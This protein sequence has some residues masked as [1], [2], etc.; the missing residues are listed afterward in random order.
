MNKMEL[1][2]KLAAATN[3]A[4]EN[5]YQNKN[6]REFKIPDL[7]V[8]AELLPVNVDPSTNFVD[9]EEIVKDILDQYKDNYPEVYGINRSGSTLLRNI[10]NTIFQI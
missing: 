3:A 7:V 5:F 9:D 2:A 1:V 6:D 8:E 10:V 4:M